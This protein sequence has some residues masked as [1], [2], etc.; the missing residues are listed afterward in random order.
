MLID[1]I[2]LT[3]W[4]GI[5]ALDTTAAFQVLISQPLVSCTVI[6][7]FLGNPSLGLSIG[8]LLELPWLLE[9][10]AGS[11][12]F[13]ESNLGATI[14]AAIAIFSANTTNRPDIAFFFAM[15]IGIAL[16][17]IGGIL[18]LWQRHQNDRIMSRIDAKEFPT[19]R[20]VWQHH[21]IGIVI[22]FLSGGIFVGVLGII[23]GYWLVPQI[24]QLVPVSFDPAFRPTRSIFLGIGVGAM[25]VHFYRKKNIKMIV[26]G[27][28]LGLVIAILEF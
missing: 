16:S 14:A 22:T 7:F 10:P 20:A 1:F 4:G 6:G 21:F 19:P 28:I 17:Y 8:I 24:I 23:F 5:V 13:S 12:R 3:I 27:I 2:K 11:A 18:V 26:L 25:L 9:I 15:I